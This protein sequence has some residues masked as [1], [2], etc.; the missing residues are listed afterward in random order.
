MP[1]FTQLPYPLGGYTL[2]R[3]LAADGEIELYEATQS[4]VERDVILRILIP[5]TGRDREAAFLQRARL[6]AATEE[7]P[8]TSRVV[9]SLRADGMWFLA[10]ERPSGYSLTD[11]QTLGHMLTASQV[12]RIIETVADIY[13]L[14]EEAELRAGVPQP[15][16]IYL[17][18]NNR[19]CLLSPLAGEAADKIATRKALAACIRPMRPVGVDGEQRI[20]T[21]LQWLETGYEDGAPVDWSTFRETCSDIRRQLEGDVAAQPAAAPTLTLARFRRRK[22]RTIRTIGRIVALSAAAAVLV[23][24]IAATGMLFPMGEQ[25]T[26]P[27]AYN[28]LLTLKR[29]GITQRIMLRPVSIADYE[30]FL[31]ALQSMPADRLQEINKDIP[32]EYA[33]HLP[34]EWEQLITAAGKQE[35]DAH[36]R[37][38]VRVNYWDALAYAR[39][40]GGGAALPDAAQLQ[41]AQ[42]HGGE[43]GLLE[44]SA[45]VTG[46][47]PMTLYPEDTP[48]LVK[49]DRSG[50]PVPADNAAMR[51]PEIGFRLIFPVP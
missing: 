40:V 36:S 23:A 14:C 29:H 31:L 45:T 25:M 37:P 20:L 27:A 38:V 9:E 32:E 4:Q 48:L 17:N 30:Q 46:E 49:M 3:F 13:A 47:N 10:E 42:Q 5:G 39:Y 51:T 2:T 33:D 24:G 15:T 7:L 6:C 43:S 16:G 8:H 41:V 28:G 11:L 50:R 26:L 21:L 19:V 22:K 35:N 1:L 44:W 34:V 18:A 12:C